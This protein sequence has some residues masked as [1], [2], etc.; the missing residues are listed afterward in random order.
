MPTRRIPQ[1][2]DH[3]ESLNEPTYELVNNTIEELYDEPSEA[4]S[5]IYIG[6]VRAALDSAFDHDSVD[7]I[8]ASLETFASSSS[9]DGVA[10]WAK[11]TLKELHL[12][13]PT[14]LRIALEAVRRGKLMTLADALQMELGIATALLV[15]PAFSSSIIDR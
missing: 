2:L 8:I 6:P 4:S 5:N 12:R 13:S 3:L 14:S 1:L 10:T 15:C 7:G 9:D 11:Q